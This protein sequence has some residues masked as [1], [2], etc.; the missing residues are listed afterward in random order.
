MN[1]LTFLQVALYGDN[2][3]TRT[4][5]IFPSPIPFPV[6]LMLYR[7]L[8]VC[9]SKFQNAQENHDDFLKCSGSKR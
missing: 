5:T 2:K 1:A 4:F 6:V 9:F 3:R 8:L 7:Y